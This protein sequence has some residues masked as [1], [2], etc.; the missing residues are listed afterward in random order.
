MLLDNGALED[1]SARSRRLAA[2]SVLR[3]KS[4]SDFE[5]L[6]STGLNYLAVSEYGWADE[7]AAL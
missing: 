1:P 7:T 5:G 6:F 4:H 2:Q 3:R